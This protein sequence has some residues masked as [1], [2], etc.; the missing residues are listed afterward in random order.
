[1]RFSRLLASFLSLVA[2]QAY[3][4]A[5]AHNCAFVHGYPSADQLKFCLTYANGTNATTDTISYKGSTYMEC[6]SNQ[7]VTVTVV[8]TN[9]TVASAPAHTASITLASNPNNIFVATPTL[10]STEDNNHFVN[11]RRRRNSAYNS[12]RRRRTGVAAA[13]Y[14]WGIVMCSGNLSA[15]QVRLYQVSS[16]TFQKVEWYEWNVQAGASL[17]TINAAATARLGTTDG[18]QNNTLSQLLFLNGE[19]GVSTSELHVQATRW[20]STMGAVEVSAGTAESSEDGLVGAIE[21]LHLGPTDDQSGVAIIAVGDGTELRPYELITVRGSPAEGA[22]VPIVDG[23]WCGSEVDTLEYAMWSSQ[24][25][26][27]ETAATNEARG[28]EYTQVIYNSDYYLTRGYSLSS[29]IVEYTL[30]LKY[31]YAY[32]SSTSSPSS[33]RYISTVPE[34]YNLAVSPRYIVRTAINTRRRQSKQSIDMQNSY[35]QH[36]EDNKN[37]LDYETF[38]RRGPAMLSAKAPWGQTDCYTTSWP[39]SFVPATCNY[40]TSYVPGYCASNSSSYLS[41]V[42]KITGMTQA[43]FTTSVQT[44]LASAVVTAASYDSVDASDVDVVSVTDLSRRAEEQSSS[45][46]RPARRVPHFITNLVTSDELSTS[47]AFQE[48]PSARRAVSSVSEVWLKIRVTSQSVASLVQNNLATGVEESTLQSNFISNASP[49]VI[50]PSNIADSNYAFFQG[51]TLSDVVPTPTPTPTYSP[52]G[53]YEEDR[54]AGDLNVVVFIGCAVALL[55]CCM[56]GLAVFCVQQKRRSMQQETRREALENS[57]AE[58]E[59]RRSQRS[60]DPNAPPTYLNSQVCTQP[61]IA[62]GDQP[63]VQLP[64]SYDD[65][66]NVEANQQNALTAMFEHPAVGV[67]TTQEP[68]PRT[69]MSS[70]DDNL[71][72]S[73]SPS[74]LQGFSRTNSDDAL[75]DGSAPPASSESGQVVPGAPRRRET[76]GLQATFSLPVITIEE[77]AQEGHK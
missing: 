2:S 60:V 47:E 22:T 37:N 41:L 57:R 40:I 5:A 31:T 59:M 24:Y 67:P 70:I 65:I 73:R 9:G 11:R 29:Y 74:N 72:L 50:T 33:S 71:R 3:L 44:A 52:G 45:A 34:I 28:R 48:L 63:G 18:E 58:I 68:V 64:P 1:M 25:S 26:L 39:T 14:G 54:S 75:I 46:G 17:Q 16:S 15:G 66:G 7:T 20:A 49:D 76:T 6:D 55:C 30:S 13:S 4:A 38:Q 32:N 10:A 53:S 23:N 42:L 61:S 77:R 27:N 62:M 43:E 19:N 69:N 8:L 36:I 56:I 12:R 35:I 21:G 51:F